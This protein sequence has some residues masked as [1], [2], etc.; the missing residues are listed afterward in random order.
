MCGF[1]TIYNSKSQPDIS[2]SDLDAMCNLIE[3]RGPDH[4]GYYHHDNLITGCR[5]LSILDLSSNANIP[6]QLF[7]FFV[8]AFEDIKFS[9]FYLRLVYIM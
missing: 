7:S 9:I 1:V 4:Y 5:R 2:Q 8:R 6:F 3:S